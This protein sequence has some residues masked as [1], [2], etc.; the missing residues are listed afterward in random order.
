MPIST[1]QSSI[2]PSIHLNVM[3]QA[4]PPKLLAVQA[5]LVQ[6]LLS[7]Q[8]NMSKKVRIAQKVAYLRLFQKDFLINYWRGQRY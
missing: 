1:F 8:F 7:Y 6:A 5:A 3:Q 4:P 2:K